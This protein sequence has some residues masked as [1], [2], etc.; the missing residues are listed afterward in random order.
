MCVVFRR[1]SPLSSGGLVGG[2][3]F[4]AWEPYISGLDTPRIGAR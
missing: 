1:D 2:Y 4:K 3:P